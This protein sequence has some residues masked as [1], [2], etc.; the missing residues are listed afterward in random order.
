MKTLRY[1]QRAG[2]MLL[3]IVPWVFGCGDEDARANGTTPD[4][5]APRFAVA[6][7]LLVAGANDLTVVVGFTDDLA[8]GELDLTATLEV[9]GAG[10]LWGVEGSG[11]FYVTRGEDLTLSKYRFEGGN[12]VVVDRLSFAQE[13]SVLAGEL[14]V[15]DGPDRGFLLQVTSGRGFEIDLESMDIVDRL[16]LSELLDPEQQPTFMNSIDVFRGR[17]IVA[18]TYA[19]NSV[20]ETVSSVSRI[21]FFDP[22]TGT[23]EARRAPC[24]GLTYN[25]EASNGD[26]YFASD[27]WVAGIHAIDPTRAPPP[28][29]VRLPADSREPDPD[30]VLLNDVTGAPT[31]GLI[32]SGGASM[33]VRVLDTERF[34]PSG[35]ATGIQLF[36]TPGW[37]TWEVNL[38]PPFEARRVDRDPLAGAL[39]YFVIDG[40]VY[41]N[42]TAADFTSTTLV[43]TTGP[44]APAPGLRIAG[45]PLSILRLR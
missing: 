16:D 26:I 5:V 42:E 19:T 12:P 28:C 30:P 21:V 27:P 31:G 11:E 37:D 36:G 32:P 33:L 34:P 41:D 14:M 24:G 4:S 25:M 15:F 7:R 17:E 18:V 29:L 3:G 2:T 1:K 22:S 13:L 6:T 9:G 23:F 40:E 35:D 43:R 8:S 10:D 20:E 38:E 44:G 39:L 45:I